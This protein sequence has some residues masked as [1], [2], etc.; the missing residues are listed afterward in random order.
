M[1]ISIKENLKTLVKS[2]LN[3]PS[4]KPDNIERLEKALKAARDESKILKDRKV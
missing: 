2:Y 1:A 3:I 4:E